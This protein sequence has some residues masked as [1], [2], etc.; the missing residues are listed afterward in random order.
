[1]A[2]IQPIC[3]GDPPPDPD[4]EFKLGFNVA[5]PG[6]F[7]ASRIHYDFGKY[8]Q[9]YHTIGAATTD[10][11]TGYPVTGPTQLNIE[12]RQGRT[13]PAGDYTATW[14]GT[15]TSTN[16]ATKTITA[17]STTV[18]W[19]FDGDLAG[20]SLKRDGDPDN[21]TPTF[22]ADVQ[23]ACVVRYMNAH[24][25]NFQPRTSVASQRWVFYPTPTGA[26]QFI[27]RMITPADIVDIS[28]Q[29]GTVPWINIHCTW[30]DT[31]IQE[32]ANE[33]AAAG[34]TTPLIVEWGN[35]NWNSSFAANWST[36]TAAASGYAGAGD[37]ARIAAYSWDRSD[38]TAEIFKTTMPGVDI[39]GVWG[40]WLSVPN[41]YNQAVSGRTRPGTFLDAMAVAPYFGQTWA[42][43]TA[44]AT[45]TPAEAITACEDDRDTRVLPHL[46]TWQGYASSS[47]LPIWF[48]ETG[49]SLNRNDNGPID[50]NLAAISNGP[51][52]GAFWADWLTYIAAN[53]PGYH[54]LYRRCGTDDA[55]GFKSHE[56]DSPGY[57]RWTES[58]EYFCG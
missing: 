51:E 22:L 20:F 9:F 49:F 53:F 26:N 21:W 44:T 39:Y 50:T 16:G 52:A 7:S 18:N 31:I 54:T 42:T 2:F 5:E 46:A 29:T 32:V 30:N 12:A 1:M 3:A 27:R 25:T 34:P 8:S 40:A 4:P 45:S 10:P 43:N 15:G 38:R 17:G 33:Y 14:S 57:P 47:G 35:E 58:V 37:T 56:L 55:F 48:Y 13:W 23:N 6:A 11:T 19:Q 41:T 28:N 24:F 36:N